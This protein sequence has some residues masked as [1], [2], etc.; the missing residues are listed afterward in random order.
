[1]KRRTPRG[2]GFRGFIF[3]PVGENNGV[4][5]LNPGPR[6]PGAPEPRGWPT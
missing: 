4:A 5:V 6:G 1:M 2:R 3:T